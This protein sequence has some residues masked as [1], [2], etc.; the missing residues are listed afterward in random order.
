MF[1]EIFGTL[2][3]FLKSHLLVIK[4]LL[5]FHNLFKKFLYPLTLSSESLTSVPGDAIESKVKRNASALYFSIRSN[6]SITFPFDLDIF[7]PFSSL[8]KACT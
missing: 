5:A 3:V 2:L 6:G 7:C 1:N 4:K 8:T